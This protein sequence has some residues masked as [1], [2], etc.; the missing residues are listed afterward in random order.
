MKCLLTE[1]QRQ[2]QD[3][4]PE[5]VDESPWRHCEQALKNHEKQA[6]R[7]Q[8]TR[9]QQEYSAEEMRKN[10]PITASVNITF[11]DLFTWAS[12]ELASLKRKSYSS[13]LELERCL[14]LTK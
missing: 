5:P 2:L 10:C 14:S 4:E 12:Q 3:G 1:V 8:D 7:L 13:C 11:N 9:Q 6:V